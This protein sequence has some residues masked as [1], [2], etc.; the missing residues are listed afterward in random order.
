MTA[1][2]TTPTS[3]AST[4]ISVHRQ[5]NEINATPISQY[6]TPPVGGSQSFAEIPKG[7]DG[8]NLILNDTGT[9]WITPAKESQFSSDYINGLTN[10]GTNTTAILKDGI[11]IPNTSTP[12]FNGPSILNPSI[13][14]TS[15]TDLQSPAV[16]AGD[17][18]LLGQQLWRYD[19]VLFNHIQ[20]FQVPTHAIKQLCIEDDLLSWPL[21]GYI[22]I[23][24]RM[25]G[26]ERSEDFNSFYYLRSDARDEISIEVNPIVAK[27]S[28]PDKIWKIDMECVVYDVEDMPS[29]DLT[30]KSKKLYFWDKKF[31]NILEKNIQWST[32]VGKR[33]ISPKISGPVAHV[34][35][36]QR[37]MF[38]GEAI[39]SLL[40]TAGYESYIDFSKWNWGKSKIMFTAKADWSIWECILYILDQ[41]ISDDSKNDVCLLQWNRGD[42]KWN[43]LPMWKLFE[44][45]GVGSPGK[46]QIEH[47]F[48][49]ENVGTPNGSLSPS[50]APLDLGASVETDIKSSDYNTITHY[51]FSQPSGLDNSKA[52]LSRPIYSHWHKK[53]QFDV[54]AKENEIKYVKDNFFKKNYVDNV[55]GTYPVMTMNMAK[56][57]EKSIDPQFSP[58]S[59][60]DPKNDRFIRSLEG[61]GKIL[62]AGLFLN[63]AMVINI[64]GSTHRLAGTFIGLDRATTSSDTI[65][66]YQVCGQYLVTN[67]KHI[68]QQQKY[69]NEIT[70]VKV[71]AYKDLPVNEGVA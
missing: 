46:G 23:D 13:S 5:I 60:L 11:P 69:G 48:F 15:I 35:D 21:R 12:L 61:R 6:K 32:A 55:L 54:D 4:G 33:Y 25:E 64:K 19:V 67:V 29:A 63:Q 59:T 24:N 56:T 17:T 43:L 62:Y 42:K 37:S 44:S 65:Y 45:A 8:K 52:F 68:I 18:K 27:G 28:L 14:T 30:L 41:Q 66:D 49:E 34:S 7:P 38:T 3:T 1:K 26:F 22:I 71:H 70:M 16:F 51:R 9:A 20:R 57:T 40:Y 50:K 47:M 39:A 10:N 58:I 2:I 36:S 31:Q 53:K